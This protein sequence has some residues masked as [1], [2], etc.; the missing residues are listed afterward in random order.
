MACWGTGLNGGADLNADGMFYIDSRKKFR[1]LTDGLSN[2]A[3]FSE[4]LLGSGNSDATLS[5][6]LGTRQY[7]DGMV[8]CSVQASTIVNAS[9]RPNRSSSN[10]MTSGQTVPPAPLATTTTLPPNAERIDCYSRLGTWKA[11]RSKHWGGVQVL[12]ADGSVHFT[13]QGSICKRG[14]I[15]RRSPMETC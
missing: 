4:T 9:T 13:N 2:T 15:C 7:P 14:A 1:D 5:A 6:I 10:G 12:Y 11:A 3:A 8:G